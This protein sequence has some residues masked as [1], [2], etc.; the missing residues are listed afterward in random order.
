MKAV[1]TEFWLPGA[2]SSMGEHLARMIAD[3]SQLPLSTPPPG[4]LTPPP[5][6]R[7]QSTSPPERLS[8][9][10]PPTAKGPPARRGQQRESVVPPGEDIPQRRNISV[11][12]VGELD[13]P[14]SWEIQLHIYGIKQG[15]VIGARTDD[16]RKITL[17]EVRVGGRLTCSAFELPTGWKGGYTGVIDDCQQGGCVWEADGNYQLINFPGAPDMELPPLDGDQRATTECIWESA[18]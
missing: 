15:T 3:G 7:Q 5:P 14:G 4:L 2:E 17:T 13:D 8:Q 1:R 6:K 9:T 10:A 12:L 11:Y 18:Q 16:G